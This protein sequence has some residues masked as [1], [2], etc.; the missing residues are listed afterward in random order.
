LGFCGSTWSGVSGTRMNMPHMPAAWVTGAENTWSTNA[1]D[2]ADFP[3]QPV[4]QFNRLW[5]MDDPDLPSRFRLIDLS[6]YCNETTVDTRRRTGWMAEG[7]AQDLR[8]LPAGVTWVGDVPFGIVEGASQ[9]QRACLF[10]A[11][12]TTPAGLYPMTVHDIPIDVTT[13]RLYFLH[14]CSVPPGRERQLYARGNPRVIGSYR[15]H[16]ADGEQVSVPLR[17]QANIHDWNSQRG[18]AQAL[19]LWQGRTRGGALATLGAIEWV[20]PRPAVAIQSIDFCS[21]GGPV[22]PVLMAISADG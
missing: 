8:E 12:E 17:Y 22:K 15:V 7:P 5:R 14:T 20:N 4:V 16:Y 18:P 3:Y 19:G 10:L 1:P 21:T 13:P 11:D 9:G 6:A 2:I